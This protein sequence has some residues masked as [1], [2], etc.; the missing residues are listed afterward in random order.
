MKWYL[1]LI[2]TSLIS[3]LLGLSIQISA[4]NNLNNNTGK[5]NID[6]DSNLEFE[7]TETSIKV[8]GN[9]QDC[10]TETQIKSLAQSATVKVLSGKNSGSGFLIA[11][12]KNVYTVV[13]NA[14][15]LVFGQENNSYEIITSDGKKYLAKP[16]DN[17]NFNNQDLGLLIFYSGENYPLI[18]LNLSAKAFVGAAGFPFNS[19]KSIPDEFVFN[20]GNIEMISDLSFRG[21]YQIGYTNLIKKGMSGGP[22]FNN[23][24]EIIG[25]N[26]R[27]KYPLWG[28][29][30]I[31]EDGTV[32][33]PEKKERMSKLS[34]GIPIQTLLKYS[35]EIKQNLHSITQKD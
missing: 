12:E 25:I 16:I 17:I 15:V 26:G 33:S 21:G 11:K 35:P 31:F 1:Q 27:H 9:N 34:W 5:P 28:N 10:L 6:L 24:G 20:K 23:K 30:Y 8:S 14:H 2:F 4:E 7:Q 13:T 18:N 3:F 22:I 29:P 19:D 32:A